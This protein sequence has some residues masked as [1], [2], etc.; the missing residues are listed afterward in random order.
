MEGGKGPQLA[1][2]IHA[3]RRRNVNVWSRFI[4]AK[5]QTLYLLNFKRLDIGYCSNFSTYLFPL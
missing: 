2:P 4:V 3:G 1:V 5:K